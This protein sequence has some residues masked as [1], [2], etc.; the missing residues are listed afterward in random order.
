[1]TKASSTYPDAADAAD[2]LLQAA[3]AAL[4]EGLREALETEQTFVSVR[5]LG[6]TT[7]ALRAET[8]LHDG[9]VAVVE[10]AGSFVPAPREN[11]ESPDDL[12]RL[13]PETANSILS[14]KALPIVRIRHDARLHGETLH[15]L[16]VVAPDVELRL[17]DVVIRGAIVSEAALAEG[18][19]PAYDEQRAPRVRVE[20]VLR[21]EED[22]A[23]P[24]VSL[25]MPDGV[26]EAVGDGA[27]LQIEGDV[28]A[29]GVRLHGR[30]SLFGQ[31]A[32]VAPAELSPGV[33]RVGSGRSPRPW[34]GAL[35]MR[36]SH[37]AQYLTYLPVGS[38]SWDDV[39]PMLDFQFPEHDTP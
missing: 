17:R 19:L 36:G 34:S 2:E 26:V 21:I 8:R 27:N 37:A 3:Q 10:T 7:R 13:T 28:V 32:S 16:V 39:Q 4:L 20:G 6:G 18:H 9:L 31:L 11:P 5:P 15:G 24:G 14:S 29:H 30:G 22:P 23:L 35:D 25:V 1:V 38:T 33:E 12:P